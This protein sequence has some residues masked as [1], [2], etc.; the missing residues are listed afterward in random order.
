MRKPTFRLALAL[1]L[2]M[3]GVSGRAA[4]QGTPVAGSVEV[5]GKLTKVMAI[6]AETSGWEIQLESEQA[7]G[8]KPVKSIEVAGNG[9]KLQKLENK[10]VT[11]SGT[12][13][14]RS[15]VET[16]DRVVLQIEKIKQWKQEKPQNEPKSN[17]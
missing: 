1:G 17:Y 6:G 15:G 16:G 4:S 9:K 11:A 13:V 14:H 8:G 5:T 12:I 3:L 7:F 2:A 10:K